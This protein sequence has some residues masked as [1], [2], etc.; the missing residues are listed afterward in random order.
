MAHLVLGCVPTARNNEANLPRGGSNGFIFEND[1]PMPER[2][3]FR[4]PI[5]SIT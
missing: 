5:A 3:R 4:L 2:D 1:S